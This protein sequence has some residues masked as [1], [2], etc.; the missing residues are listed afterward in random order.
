[1]TKKKIANV[2]Y[3]IIK[4]KRSSHNKRMQ[5]INAERFTNLGQT[6]GP[7]DSQLK[8]RTCRIW[9]FAVPAEYRVK[10]K[11]REKRVEYQ[12][13]TREQKQTMEH[14]SDCDINSNWCAWNDPPRIGKGT[15]GI[16]NKRTG[17]DTALLIT[18]KIM[19]RVPETWGYFLTLKL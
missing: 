8:K 13:R 3:A 15:R 1:M 4:T 10:M 12:D 17:G 18:A 14:E 11:K 19:G 9:D 16:G 5:K 7:R 2:D 6:T